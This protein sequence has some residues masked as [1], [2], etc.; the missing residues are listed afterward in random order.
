MVTCI[1]EY[2]TTMKYN[3]YEKYFLFIIISNSCS[4]MKIPLDGLIYLNL[5]N[6]YVNAIINDK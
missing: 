1:G 4:R 3:S 6:Q 5:I 2:T